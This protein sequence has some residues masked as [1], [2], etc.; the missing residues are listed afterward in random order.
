MWF[1]YID[2][3]TLDLWKDSK[4]EI[5]PKILRNQEYPHFIHGFHTLFGATIYSSI[6][7]WQ[8]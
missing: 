3:N 4:Y 8:K 6:F 5:D 1:I 2:N 7:A